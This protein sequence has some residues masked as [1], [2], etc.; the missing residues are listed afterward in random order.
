MH[1][2]GMLVGTYK[3]IFT[4]QLRQPTADNNHIT[5]YNLKLQNYFIVNSTIHMISAG[6][7]T[8]FMKALVGGFIDRTTVNYLG[9]KRG[10]YAQ[11]AIYGVTF[12]YIMGRLNGSKRLNVN[13]LINPRDS[14]GEIMMNVVL[15][16]F[17]QKV[18]Q[19]LYRKLLMDKYEA[20]ILK[21]THFEQMMG[22][23]THSPYKLSEEEAI[24]TYMQG[25]TNPQ[26]QAMP[27]GSMMPGI[28]QPFN[29]MQ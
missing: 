16:Y 22:Q 29:P 2:F 4:D 10:L 15:K 23:T 11:I 13:H 17:P 1:E 20:Q 9:T 7:A 24:V 27:Q 26:Q 3:H 5:N 14:N 21:A 25:N 6:M 12:Y 18:N 28:Q 8:F 19:E